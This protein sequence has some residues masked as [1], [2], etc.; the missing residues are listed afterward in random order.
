MQKVLSLVGSLAL[1]FSAAAVGAQ[2]LPGEWYASLEK[3]AFTP[4]S[5][6]FAPVW[7]TLYALIA[8]SLWIIWRRR[9]PVRLRLQLSLFCAQLVLNAAWSWLFF[10]LHRP[11]LGLIDI[12]ALLVMICLTIAAFAPTS[13]AA[14]ALLLPYALWVGFAT[15][16]NA[17]IWQLNRN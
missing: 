15:L 8:L 2:Y 5:G 3:P 10:G 13:R 7:T 17:A 1:T 12:V 4:P 11:D 16:L 6:V 9:D 14:A